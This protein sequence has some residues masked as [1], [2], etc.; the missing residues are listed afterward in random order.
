MLL[1]NKLLLMSYPINNIHI[2]LVLSSSFYYQVR[3]LLLITSSHLNK[4]QLSEYNS[5]RGPYRQIK[6][7]LE[8]NS[9]PF[10]KVRIL[11]LFLITTHSCRYNLADAR[12]TR[13]PSPLSYLRSPRLASNC[14][15]FQPAS[16]LDIS[17]Y[18]VFRK[19]KEKKPG[20]MKRPAH[21]T[22]TCFIGR[23]EFILVDIAHAVRK[24][25]RVGVTNFS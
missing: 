16:Y 1:I 17:S 3:P 10:L 18:I 4:V 22:G 8:Y 24:Q 11:V 19:S 23:I 7:K 2:P 25:R 12:M 14:F 13:G 15:K 21:T 5:E 9:I 6:T 20:L